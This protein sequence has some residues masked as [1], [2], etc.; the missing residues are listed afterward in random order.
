M[1]VKRRAKLDIHVHALSVGHGHVRRLAAA[2][3][4][5]WQMR[6][7]GPLPRRLG[8]KTLIAFKTALL[9]RGNSLPGG[10]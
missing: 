9:I 7:A 2:L 10:V 5:R 6:I 3:H 8:V 1:P 4:A